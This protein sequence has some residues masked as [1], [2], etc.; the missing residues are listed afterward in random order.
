M[1][2]A[3]PL[4]H[5]ALPIPTPTA[6]NTRLPAIAGTGPT[7]E[8]AVTLAVKDTSRQPTVVALPVS[9]VNS[10]SVQRTL[11]SPASQPSTP[12]V[13]LTL[14][15]PKPAVPGQPQTVAAPAMTA[16]RELEVVHRDAQVL[17]I[18]YPVAR[19]EVDDETICKV[20]ATE[21][22]NLLLLG[23]GKGTTSLT[24]WPQPGSLDLP[25]QQYRVSVR[26]AW[27]VDAADMRNRNLLDEAQASL[28]ELFPDSALSLRSHSNGSLSVFGKAQSNDQA[29]Q[30]IQLVRKMFLVPVIDRI[31][32]TTP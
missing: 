17:E 24:V 18:S 30:I 29:K 23:I 28:S 1:K 26:D 10:L 25:P 22:T 11:A 16:V 7:N 3:T 20:L 6:A 4:P 12:S 32:V 2:V 14:E 5:P 27:S 9:A 13:A 15:P 21:S 8:P 19:I 31:A